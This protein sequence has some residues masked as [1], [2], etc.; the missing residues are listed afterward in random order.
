MV[1][2][3]LRQLS[4]VLQLVPSLGGGPSGSYY[5]L[6]NNVGDAGNN[7]AFPAT[8]TAGWQTAT[9]SMDIRARNIEAD[10]FGVGF[11]DVVTHGNDLVRPGTGWFWG[12]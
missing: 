1:S 5:K 2:T 9:L 11:V 3:T 12:C 7:I 8:G 4:E 10:G 6:L